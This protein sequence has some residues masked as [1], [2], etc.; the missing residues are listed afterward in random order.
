MSSWI[1]NKGHLSP[2][3]RLKINYSLSYYYYYHFGILLVSTL[4]ATHDDYNSHPQTVKIPSTES[5]TDSEHKVLFP[6][7]FRWLLIH[8]PPP[9]PSLTLGLEHGWWSWLV[10]K[11][12]G[13]QKKCTKFVCSVLNKLWQCTLFW[14]TCQP[15]CFCLL[16]V[17]VHIISI[18]SWT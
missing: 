18:F 3:Y 15:K 12:D 5:V 1:V 6:L 7:W 10:V 16:T 14:L 4:T 9:H 13:L 17:L 2:H 11:L 8:P